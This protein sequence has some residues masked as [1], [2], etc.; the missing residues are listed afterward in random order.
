[1]TSGVSRTVVC[2]SVCV[3]CSANCSSQ[4]MWEDQCVFVFAAFAVEVWCTHLLLPQAVVPPPVQG[5]GPPSLCSESCVLCLVP[6]SV[7]LCQCEVGELRR[8]LCAGSVP[9]FGNAVHL[10]VESELTIGL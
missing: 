10:G 2:V 8:G 7:S 3:C 4:L 6:H 5:T 1:M 9:I